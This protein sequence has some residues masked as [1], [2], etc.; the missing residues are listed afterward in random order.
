M[1]LDAILAA[2][3]GYVS[4][5][6]VWEEL[7]I[8]LLSATTVQRE[9]IAK[10]KDDEIAKRIYLLQQE[11]RCL[12]VIDDI[13]SIETWESLKAAFPLNQRTESS[14]EKK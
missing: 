13:W 2:L 4:L 1:K 5:N 8:K 14:E 10:M 7:L 3:F 11:H 6:N 9:E 12:V